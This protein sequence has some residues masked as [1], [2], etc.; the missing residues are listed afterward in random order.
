M[1]FVTRNRQGGGLNRDYLAAGPV[2]APA[3][4][5]PARLGARL[6]CAANDSGGYGILVHAPAQWDCRGCATESHLQ[7]APGRASLAGRLYGRTAYGSG[8]MV[9][10]LLTHPGP[11][12]APD[13]AVL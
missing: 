4:G 7:P 13:R 11:A 9:G 5:R 10:S 12:R 2:R 8:S 6:T 3:V 1:G